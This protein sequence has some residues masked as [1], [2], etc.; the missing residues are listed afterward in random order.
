MCCRDQSTLDR[1]EQEAEEYHS[2]VVSRRMDLSSL[3][4]EHQTLLQEYERV[5]QRLSGMQ[6]GTEGGR[7]Q[8]EAQ[9]RSKE[10]AVR[11]LQSNVGK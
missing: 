11:V 2:R 9:L 3:D 6:Q 10:S 8:A 5:Q 7:V 1:L 4:R